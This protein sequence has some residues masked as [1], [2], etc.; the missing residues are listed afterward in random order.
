[1]MLVA[2]TI[3]KGKFDVCDAHNIIGRCN[4]VRNAFIYS[5]GTQHGDYRQTT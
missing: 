3:F 1:M 2:I 4:F 5:F